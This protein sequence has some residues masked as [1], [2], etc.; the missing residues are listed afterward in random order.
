M[1]CLCVLV[2]SG[3][4]MQH[5]LHDAFGVKVLFHDRLFC[6]C[7]E[8]CLGKAAVAD[9]GRAA[10]VFYRGPPGIVALE[11][12]REGERERKKEKKGI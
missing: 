1:W 10:P 5:R 11:E 6:V 9:Y 2:L 8:G 3:C 7:Y 12:S 4:Y